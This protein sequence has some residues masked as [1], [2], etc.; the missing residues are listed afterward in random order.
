MTRNFSIHQGHVLDVLKGMESESVHCVVTSPP[1]FGLRDY[2]VE[3]AVWDS[4]VECEHDW[5]DNVRVNPNGSG[6]QGE[7]S[8]KQHTNVGSN[9]FDYETRSIKSSFCLCGAWRGCFG[10]E[11]T[12]SLYVQHTVQIM[13]EVRRVLRPDGTLWLNLGDS[14]AGSWGNY[15]GQNC[16]N[17]MRRERLKAKDLCMIPARVALALQGDGWWL[18]SDVVWA[19]QNCMPES[20]TDRPT[21][22]HEYIFL[23]TKSARYFY[24]AA[25]I[26]EPAIYDVDGTG[27]AARKARQT[28]SNKSMPTSERAGIRPAGLKDNRNFNG[29]NGDK[30]RG[31]S[32][33]HDGFNDHWDLMEKMEQCTGYRNKRD[34]WTIAPAQFPDAHFAVFPTKLIEPCI[35]AGTSQRGVCAECGAPLARTVAR[36]GAIHKRE[37][38]HVPNNTVTKVDS[39]GWKPATMDTDEWQRSC[40]HEGD[41]I[42]ATVLDPFSGAGTTGLVALRHGRNFIGIELNPEYVTMA[43]RRIQDDAPLFNMT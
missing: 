1:Y 30:Q 13:R 23:L 9:A 33:R 16:G 31:H 39:T 3:P 41:P 42:P 5:A 14:Y 12:P 4:T 8:A 34:V 20:V 38:A 22:S 25:A 29:K 32:R 26:K 15:G 18:R 10:L 7:A 27:T 35:L 6:G 21:R 36:T 28:G 11:P 43:T 17:G 19:K 2:G 37:P 24:D 40:K